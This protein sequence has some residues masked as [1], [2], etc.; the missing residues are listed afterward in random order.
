MPVKYIP[1]FPEP[2]QGQAI[3]NNFIRT[4]RA[5]KHRDNDQPIQRILRGL[6]L[7][8]IQKVETVGANPDGNLLIRGECLAACAYLKDKGIAVDLVYIDPPFASGADYAKTVFVRRNPKVAE[9]ISKEEEKLKDTELQAFDEKMYGDIWN[10]EAYLNWMYENLMAIKSVMSETGSIY[11]HLDWHI[12]HYVKI[13][14]DEIFGEGNF[15]NE[16]VYCYSGGAVPVDHLPKKHDVIFWYSKNA[17]QWLYSPIYKEYSEK[18]KQRGRTAVKG[19]NAGL[20]KE[21]TPQTDW[22]TDIAPVT[23]PT[24]PEKQYYVTQ[25]P[26]SL[27]RRIINLSAKSGMTVADF[28]GGSGVTAKAAY[29]SE[30]KFIHVDIGINSIQITRDRLMEAG[31]SFHILEVQDGVALFRN[32]VQ[33]MDKLKSIIPGMAAAIGLSNLWA[34]AI[35]GSKEGMMPVYLPNLLDHTTKVLDIPMMNR[36]VQEELPDLPDNIKKVVVYYIDVEDLAALEKFIAEVNG[37]EIEVELRDLKQVL[38]DVVV[39]DVVE[40]HLNKVK[41]KYT[42]EIKK[43]VSDRLMQKIDAYNQKKGLNEKKGQIELEVVELDEDDE[44]AKPIHPFKPIQISEEGLELIELVSLDCTSADG[45]WH[46]DM[47]IKID[48]KGYVISNGKKTKTF[49]DAKI[50]SEKKP[51]RVKV[52]NIAGDETILAV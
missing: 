4:Q 47:E 19:P 21:G 2:I 29:A 34:G 16:I 44:E 51:L 40:F 36:I 39:N 27:L 30:C 26:E 20:R 8:E 28:F 23:S 3:L 38:H 15:H 6:P 50:F 45:I 1:Y 31:A 43:F 12:G 52:R 14:L 18:T 49:W 11:V 24:D 5:L 7:Y 9:A 48:K 32:P 41:S 35:F 42:I 25:K 37:T 33:T 22:W 46:S 13:L 17:Y 10:K